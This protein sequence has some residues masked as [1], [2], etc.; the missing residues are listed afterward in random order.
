M[1]ISSLSQ[2][3]FKLFL[4]FTEKSKVLL[5]WILSTFHLIYLFNIAYHLSPLFLRLSAH[6][7]MNLLRNRPYIL[8]P[9][10]P[11]KLPDTV[12]SLSVGAKTPPPPNGTRALPPSSI[13]SSSNAVETVAVPPAD[14]SRPTCPLLFALPFAFPFR[15]LTSSLIAHP[16]LAINT[17]CFQLAN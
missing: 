4:L 12:P 6:R 14:G 3:S 10:T 17:S 8:S 15:F 16:P 7:L 11:D 5:K 1:I 9:D 2:K 13:Q